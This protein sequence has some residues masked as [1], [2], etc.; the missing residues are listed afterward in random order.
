MNEEAADQAES[1]L[2]SRHA[3]Y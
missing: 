1:R 2:L 3:A